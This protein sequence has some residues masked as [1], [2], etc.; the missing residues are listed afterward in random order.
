MDSVEP[1][2]PCSIPGLLHGGDSVTGWPSDL[3]CLPLVS[4][5]KS[6]VPQG[7]ERFLMQGVIFRNGSLGTL[8][9]KFLLILPLF[10]FVNG[11]W[12]SWLS[13]AEA[14]SEPPYPFMATLPLQTLYSPF[15]S[16]DNG[17]SQGGWFGVLKCSWLRLHGPANGWNR[18]LD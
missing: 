12:V 13:M 9:F 16:E 10:I 6:S 1:A 11:L 7:Q 4:F 8:P 15:L 5:S 14:G 17:C 18:C 3:G 2:C